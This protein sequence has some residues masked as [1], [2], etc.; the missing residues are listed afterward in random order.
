MT[1]YKYL[2]I[3]GGIASISAV[4]TLRK[5][6]VDSIAI[7][8]NESYLPYKRTQLSKKLT[9]NEIQNEF[10]LLEPDWYE[11]NDVQ[12]IHNEVGNIDPNKKVVLMLDGQSISYDYLVIATGLHAQIPIIKGLHPHDI[13][14]LRNIHQANIIIKLAQTCSEVLVIGGGVEGVEIAFQLVIMGLKVTIIDQNSHLMSK[15]LSAQNSDFL[16]KQAVHAGVKVLTNTTILKGE[17]LSDNIFVVYTNSENC[18]QFDLIIAA[19]GALPNIALAQSCGIGTSQGII[20]N[21]YLQTSIPSIYSAGDVV[22]IPA[23]KNHHLWHQAEY[24]GEVVAKNLLGT[25]TKYNHKEFRL[26]SEVFDNYFFS[27]NIEAQNESSC[28]TETETNGIKHRTLYFNNNK[29]C[30]VEMINDGDNAKLYQMGVWEKWSKEDL[31][32]NIPWKS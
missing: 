11:L 25:L 9:G 8:N 5:V 12:L 2:F 13:K 23:H 26:K 3:G 27:L 22:D 15:N 1:Q 10:A 19:V 24:M 29:L 28:I 7:I 31:E 18:Y 6:S 30:G 32:K 14:V 21:D 4:K 17:K 16:K 20:V